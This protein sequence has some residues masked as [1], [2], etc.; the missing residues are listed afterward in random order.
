VRIAVYDS[1]IGGLHV[2]RACLL[3]R[4]DVDWVYIADEDFFPAGDR[5]AGVVDE[6]LR[7][8]AS[9]LRSVGVEV[10]LPAAS[11]AWPR[12][13]AFDVDGLAVVDPVAEIGAAVDRTVH[14][15]AMLGVLGPPATID[16]TLIERIVGRRPFRSESSLQLA[17]VVERGGDRDEL[18][19]EVVRSTVS[20][21]VDDGASL[22]VPL[23]SH[24]CMVADV[25]QRA[26]GGALV[27]D[28]AT[29]VAQALE[30]VIGRHSSATG[31]PALTLMAPM[32]YLEQVREAVVREVQLI[33]SVVPL[34]LGSPRAPQQ[35][36]A[37]V[38]L[39]AYAAFNAGRLGELLALCAPGSRHLGAGV[40]LKQWLSERVAACHGRGY[41]ITETLVTGDLVGVTGIAYS[42]ASDESQEFAHRLRIRD[43]LVV[44]FDIDIP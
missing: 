23:D 24:A 41:A 20:R 36:A 33:P 5:T 8:V 22:V 31:E 40:G 15:R 4:G 44:D 25:V 17:G 16:A 6:R 13:S 30:G 10:V 1:G 18:L 38:A 9:M 21:F 2:L 35:S 7:D 43:G 42:S 28:T 26:S 32:P 27:L 12:L 39:V 37:D 14:E 29:H 34:A 3:L 19:V 11:Y